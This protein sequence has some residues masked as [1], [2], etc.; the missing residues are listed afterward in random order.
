MNPSKRIF[1]SSPTPNNKEYIAWLEK[2][3]GQLKVQW[4]N[5]GIF[6]IIQLSRTGPKYNQGMMLASILFWE[7]STNT[8]QVPYGMI[9]PTLFNVAA[10][11]GLLPLGE[12]FDPTLKSDIEFNFDNPDFKQYIIDHHDKTNATV[13]DMEHIAF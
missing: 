9:T 11:T 8:F 6:D 2:V 10:I 1:R 12:I 4:E 3:Q 5:L 7:G 13:S